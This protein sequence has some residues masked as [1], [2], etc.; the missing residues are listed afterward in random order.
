M[1]QTPLF[2]LKAASKVRSTSFHAPSVPHIYTLRATVRHNLQGSPGLPS[3]ISSLSPSQQSADHPSICKQAH[4]ES[5]SAAD[6]HGQWTLPA[7][8]PAPAGGGEAGV[9]G[10]AGE[11]G[12]RGRQPHGRGRRGGAPGAGH[13]PC[14]LPRGRFLRGPPDPRHFPRREAPAG[15][16]LLRAPRRTV[17]VRQGAHRRHARRAVGRARAG[18]Q[19]EEQGGG[20]PLI[21]GAVPVRVRQGR[22]RRAAHQGPAGVH[23]EGDHLRRRRPGGG[24]G[25]EDGGGAVQHAGAE[26]A[27]RAAGG[28]EE[29]A[30]GAEAGDHSG[31]R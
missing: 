8:V 27:L 20:A 1:K 3:S 30:V 18:E 31:G 26:A 17:P 12:R 5:T 13:G 2:S 25:A 23:R 24:G 7:P 9:L 15:A 4:F 16:D 14:G 10:R 19:G 21:S 11:A 6:I 22:R 28:A 29:P